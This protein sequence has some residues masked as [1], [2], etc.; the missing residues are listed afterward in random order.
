MQNV[1]MLLMVGCVHWAVLSWMVFV[2]RK[3]R[4]SVILSTK[5]WLCLI[6][7]VEVYMWICTKS[8]WGCIIHN[9]WL[10]M[11]VLMKLV[12]GLLWIIRFYSSTVYNPHA[13]WKQIERNGVRM[14]F[15]FFYSVKHSQKRSLS[16][17]ASYCCSLHSL[18]S[19]HFLHTDYN[20]SAL[21]N[22]VT[23]LFAGL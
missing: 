23:Y 14:M 8:I 10:L 17:I 3:S 18:K 11:I 16:G 9:T 20:F 19:S 13:V 5:H 4:H 6:E 2:C 12:T 21:F 22:V 7:H 1:L 15:D